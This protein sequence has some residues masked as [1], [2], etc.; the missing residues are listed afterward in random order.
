MQYPELRYVPEAQDPSVVI[1]T[2]EL[3]VKVIDNTGLALEETGKLSHFERYENRCLSPVSHHLGYHGVRCLY[4]KV[5][6][7][8]LVVPLTS[9]LN[10]QGAEL[11]GIDT[12]PVDERSCWGVARGWPMRLTPKGGGV[13]LDL[14]PMPS[15]QFAYSL[16]IQPAEPNGIDFSVRFTFHRRP[17][18]GDVRFRASW[19]CYMNAQDDV[20]LWYPRGASPTDFVW[21]SLGEL[22]DI[23]LGDA[24]GY[25][26]EQKSFAAQEQ[27]VPLG[28]G[29]IGD[30]ALVLMFNDPSV[31]FFVVNSGGHMSTSSVQNPAWDF[32]WTIEDYPLDEPVGFD[33]R[34]VYTPFADRQQVLEL[35]R[36]WLQTR[37]AE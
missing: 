7:R 14:D 10:L 3:V 34:I 36:Q 13:V 29:R 18:A 32:E 6:K 22:P 2:T 12:D 28:Y 9:W 35:Y 26:H 31:R 5:E 1:E 27:V 16:E 20:C 17:D 24:V 30:S 15:T 8:N 25:V 37:V 11:A 4:N 21:D 23:I 33:G 19:P